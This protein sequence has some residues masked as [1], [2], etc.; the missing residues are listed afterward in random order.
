M[1]AILSISV[2]MSEST[3]VYIKTEPQ[4]WTVGFYRPEDHGGGWEIDGDFPSR[5]EAAQRVRWLNGGRIA[6]LSE[7]HIDLILNSLAVL[8]RRTYRTQDQVIMAGDKR[9]HSVDPLAVQ[10]QSILRVR[11]A[12][13]GN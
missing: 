12:Q 11:K 7:I 13:R 8:L 3:W 1:V 9:D 2:P 5:D 6:E 4:L 10:I